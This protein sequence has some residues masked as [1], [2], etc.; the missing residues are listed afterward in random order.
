MKH[1]SSNEKIHSLHVKGYNMAKN[2]SNLQMQ[3]VYT[4]TCKH[5]FYTFYSYPYRRQ[6]IQSKN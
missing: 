1:F 4:A 2:D 3:V 5:Q 6:K